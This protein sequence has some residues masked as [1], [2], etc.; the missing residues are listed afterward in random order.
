MRASLALAFM[1]ALSACSGPGASGP[2]APAGAPQAAAP[3]PNAKTEEA[4]IASALQQVQSKKVDYRISGADLLNI[5]V[6]GEK[7]MDRQA[8]VGQNGM[9]SFPLVGTVK[10]GGLTVPEA[11]AALAGKLGDFLKNPQVTIFIKEYGNKKV[12]VFGQVT[13]PG[14]VELPTEMKMTVLEAISQAGGF[15]PIAAPDRT[16]VVR[17]VNGQS[18]SFVVEVSA[19]TKRGEKQKDIALEPNDIVFVPESFF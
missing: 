13:K 4:A 16:K 12:F 15:T 17:L 11:E 7:D 9:I 6:F 8:R 18:V 19:I 10:V 3:A 14:A 2:A 1:F 5:T